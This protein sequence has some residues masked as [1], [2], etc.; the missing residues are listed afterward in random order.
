[1]NRS[2]LP[3]QIA[4]HWGVFWPQVKDERVVAVEPHPNDPDP[5]PI[6]RSLAG[7]ENDSARIRQPFV[8]ASF[9]EC[10]PT[11]TATGRGSE[12][13]VPVDWDTALDLAARELGRVRRDFGNASIFGGSYG[14]ASAGRFHHA[15]SQVHRFLNCFGGYVRSVNT[16]S[17]AAMEVIVPRV[18]CSIEDLFR[19]MPSWSAISRHTRLVVA[20][21]G[22]ATKN[23]Q[24]NSGGVGRHT[25]RLQQIEC[26]RAGVRFVNVS[27]IR[28]DVDVAL[29][30]TWLAVA[31]NTD[32]ALMLGLAHTLVTEGLHDRWFLKECCTGYDRFERYLLGVAGGQAK[33]AEWAAAICQIP[34]TTIREL[35]RDMAANR[36]LIAASWSLQRQ[37]HGEQV[38]W[39]AITLAAMTGSMGLPGGGFGAGYG[40]EHA[41]GNVTRSARVAAVPQGRNPVEAFIPVARIADM[42]LSPGEPF[43]YD[44]QLLTYP[45]IR[46]VY[47]CGGNPFHHHQD[48][49]RLRAAWQRPEVV[50][51]HEPWWTTTAR[52]ADIVF[53]VT[54]ALERDD[55]SGGFYDGAL[56]ACRRALAPVGQARDDYD[57]F[58]GLAQRLGFE[59]EFTAELDASD[60]LKW[61]YD[62]TR[63]HGAAAGITLPTF[64]EFWAEGW[65]DFPTPEEPAVLCGSLRTHQSPL[66]TP[67]GR[68]EIWSDTIAGFD[69]DDCPP[70][71]TWIEPVEWLGTPLATRFPMHLISNQPR[72]R[73]HSQYDH[74][75]ESRSSK[76]AGREPLSM[77]P[78]DAAARRLAAGDIVRVFNERGA[79]LAGLIV[80]DEIRPGVVQL[81][82]GAWFDPHDSSDAPATCV[83]GNPNVLTRDVGTSRL[84]QGPSA[85]STLVQVERFVGDPPPVRAFESPDI[86]PC[87]RTHA[88]QSTAR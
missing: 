87:P 22:L 8:R 73:L 30:P 53:P 4:T 13:F 7:R 21:G 36:T 41:V 68:V 61:L 35:A 71:P 27:P 46:L 12:P 67:S 10:G 75:V 6:G 18:L 72:T 43:D 58:C 25:T 16:Y 19:G 47:W 70:H 26:R 37:D 39:M 59:K 23:A 45:D 66:P 83:H 84:A 78:A 81:A 54:T 82:T 64:D 29:E 5:S 69:Y 79:C 86:I 50:I 62:E 56:V 33:D 15:Q 2:T 52:H 85:M 76:I 65:Y 42:L 20:F 77:N 28:G 49:N 14:W 32:V 34:A 31:P 24:V 60:W 55:L 11:P 40:A 80:S 51:V 63:R 17:H 3:P 38:Y 88:P 9:L 44:G 74:G 1:M 48:L 57:V